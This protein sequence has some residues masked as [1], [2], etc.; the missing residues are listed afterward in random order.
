MRIPVVVLSGFLGSGKTTLLLRL[1]KEAKARG[2]KPGIL[3]NEL[4]QLDVDGFTVNEFDDTNIQKLLDGCVCCSKKSELASSLNRLLPQK[5]DVIFIEL[6]GVANPEEIAD[7]LTE[8]GL[9]RSMRLKQIITVLDAENVLDYNSVFSS[10]RQLVHTLRR[11]I[12]AADFI[13][14]NKTDLVSPS[15]LQKIE[16]A[17]RKQNDR[18]S[19]AYTTHSQVDMDPLFHGIEPNAAN[20]VSGD[21]LA[22]GSALSVVKRSIREHEHLHPEPSYSRVRTMMLPW[23]ESN[24]PTREKLEKFL[25]QRRELLLRAKGYVTLPPTGQPHLFQ[26]AGKRMYWETTAFSGSP[27]LVIIGIDLDE[28]RLLH[29]WNVLCEMV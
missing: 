25:H 26:Y 4:G 24:P 6:T 8:P 2:V 28:E 17:I 10:D 3:M 1:V 19:I 7:A 21:R 11:Q 20:A 5:P 9:L 14:V 12:E 29:D 15:V 16:K 22:R 23:T 18:C 13:I 27:Y